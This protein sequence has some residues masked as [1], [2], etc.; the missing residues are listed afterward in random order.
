MV[1]V[2]MSRGRSSTLTLSAPPAKRLSLGGR[3]SADMV[4]YGGLA[5]TTLCWASAFV[6][7]KRVL[8]EFHPLAVAALRYF[9]AAAI[10]A[11]FAVRRGAFAGGRSVV[12]PLAVLVCTGGVLYPWLFFEALSRTTASNTSLLIALNPALTVVLAPLLG[13][14]ISGRQIAGFALA[15]GGAMLVIPIDYGDVEHLQS[16]RSSIA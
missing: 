1:S 6:I 2:G 16:S 15:L 9:V 10:L 11:P 14:R 5:I 4:A 8:G 3:V 7:G 12:K 13:E